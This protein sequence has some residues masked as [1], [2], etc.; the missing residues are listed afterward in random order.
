MWISGENQND[1]E[2]NKTLVPIHIVTHASQL[3]N[4]F[5]D[6]SP[7]KPLVVGFDCEGVSLCRHGSLCI[8]QVNKM[9]RTN[10]S[11]TILVESE[12]VWQRRMC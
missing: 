10:R 6:P 7:E 5:V 1:P 9:L 2:A 8:M 3:P 11:F 4:E 12:I